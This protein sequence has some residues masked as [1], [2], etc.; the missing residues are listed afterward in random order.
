M[1]YRI[2]DDVEIDR[3]LTGFSVSPGQ[4]LKAIS[5]TNQV[6][7]NPHN[8]QLP[9]LQL[10]SLSHTIGDTFQ[11]KFTEA[12]DTIT[13]PRA[14]GRPDI[15]PGEARCSSTQEFLNYPRG[16]ELKTTGGAITR[17]NVSWEYGKPRIDSITSL[18][19][20]SGMVKSR[21]PIMGIVWDFV[22]GAPAITAATYG[23]LGV[24]DWA[25]MTRHSKAT[26]VKN[27]GLKKL[28]AGWLAIID[29]EPYVSRY[30]KML[31]LG[32]DLPLFPQK[33]KSSDGF[34]FN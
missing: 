11:Y 13:N 16:L 24:D 1:N 26:R 32:A 21:T 7:Q 25:S 2:N 19:F 8:T 18:S 20:A 4:L 29:R 30:R 23:S 3:D 31:G 12:T 34:S 28:G 6:L 14:N 22:A 15:L 10:S 5:D 27:S 17:G 33:S 9:M